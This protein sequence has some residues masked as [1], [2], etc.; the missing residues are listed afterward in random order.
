MAVG[1]NISSTTSCFE[2]LPLV[3][4]MPQPSVFS[5][6]IAPPTAHPGPRLVTYLTETGAT[7]MK[8]VIYL[9]VSTRGRLRSTLK[10]VTNHP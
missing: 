8:L 3:V 7:L 2:M 5:D 10:T 4:F 6:P 1:G 9:D